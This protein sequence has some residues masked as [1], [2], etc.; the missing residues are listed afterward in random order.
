MGKL[1]RLNHSWLPSTRDRP[2]VFS[3][4]S[5]HWLL[6][7]AFQF[8]HILQGFRAEFFVAAS[9]SFSGQSPQ[10]LVFE[11]LTGGLQNFDKV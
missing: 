5:N 4:W 10:N 9:V 2:S 6:H 3:L 1:R 7:T 8:T 11:S